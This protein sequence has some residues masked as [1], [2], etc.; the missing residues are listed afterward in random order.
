MRTALLILVVPSLLLADQPRVGTTT[1]QVLKLD[2][3]ARGAALGGAFLAL[4]D[5][6]SAAFYNPAGLVRAER[7][8]CVLSYVALPANLTY[9]TGSFGMKVTDGQAFGLTFGGLASEEMPVRTPHRPEGTGETFVYSTFHAGLCYSRWMT[10]RFSFGVGA[11]YLRIN[12]MDDEYTVDTWSASLGSLYDVG[13]RDT[14]FG[15]VISNFG[16]DI[17]AIS[18]S[19]G[20]PLSISLGVFTRGWETDAH[21][22]DVVALGSRPRDTTEQYAVGVEYWYEGILALRGGYRFTHDALSWAGG[23][24]LNVRTGRRSLRVDYAYLDWDTL[25]GTHQVSLALAF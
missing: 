9:A 7:P 8:Q 25:G 6:A 21:R 16:P 5:D 19:Y 23:A 10:D 20:Q 17:T 15:V 14:R 22:L 3:S 1:G 13:W 18:E 24:G 4:A 11:R 2:T 12:F